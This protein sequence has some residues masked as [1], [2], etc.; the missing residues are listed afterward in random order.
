MGRYEKCSLCSGYKVY[1]KVFSAREAW[2]SPKNV[3][4]YVPRSGCSF[5][6]LTPPPYTHT[7]THTHIERAALIRHRG[8]VAENICGFEPWEPSPTPRFFLLQ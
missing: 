8:G 2:H 4:H 3:T 1:K 7:H 5:Y 6:N